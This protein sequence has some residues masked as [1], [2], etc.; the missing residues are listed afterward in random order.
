[1]VQDWGYT[2][3]AAIVIYIFMEIV[4]RLSFPHFY[5]V[6]KEVEDD[7]KRTRSAQKNVEWFAK[8]IYSIIMVIW[9][10][11]IFPTGTTYFPWYLG[12]SG[13]ADFPTMYSN[14]PQM[15]HP[16]EIRAYYLVS[17]GFHLFQLFIDL[18]VR[19]WRNDFT[20]KMLHHVLMIELG[21]GS[22]MTNLL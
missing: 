18:F 1:M 6:Q 8:G 12:G 17:M 5:S 10:H 22:Y 21:F 13:A 2:I 3:V 15:S 4:Q 7:D 19:E 11:Q 16:P 20:G 14:Y 9:A